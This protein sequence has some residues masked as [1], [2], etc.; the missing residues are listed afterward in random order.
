MGVRRIAV[1]FRGIDTEIRDI[2]L[3]VSNPSSTKFQ[4]YRQYTEVKPSETLSAPLPPSA[5]ASYFKESD[6]FDKNT[7]LD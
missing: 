6:E 7:V 3:Q 5:R 1:F 4:I 2:S